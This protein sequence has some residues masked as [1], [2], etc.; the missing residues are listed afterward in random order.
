MLS[1]IRQLEFSL[2]HNF[3]NKIECTLQSLRYGQ[4]AKNR[5]RE[6]ISAGCTVPMKELSTWK[7]CFSR[8]DADEMGG[9]APLNQLNFAVL[10]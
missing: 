4:W 7:P 10:S 6:K 2:G 8:E 1:K 9:D 5:F 3:K